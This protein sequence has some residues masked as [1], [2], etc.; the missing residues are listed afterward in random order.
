MNKKII[1][2]LIAAMMVFTFAGCGSG[3]K[4]AAE[5][6]PAAAEETTE[7]AT[8]DTAE[9]ATE[10]TTEAA[11]E[12]ATDDIGVEKATE[13]ALSDAGFS[14]GEVEFTK[15]SADIDDGISIYEI[16]FI[17]GETKYEY[18]IDAGTGKILD[19]DTDSIYDD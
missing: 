18:D 16:E 2:I 6:A 1:A 9:A 3:Q 12:T 11:T 17:N 13:I 10:E 19:K 5:E 4:E 14:S 7:A 8:E 15:Q